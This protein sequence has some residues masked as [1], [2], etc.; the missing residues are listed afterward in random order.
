MLL[1]LL[2]LLLL[3]VLD[4]ALGLPSNESESLSGVEG[5][6]SGVGGVIVEAGSEAGRSLVLGLGGGGGT[7]PA[8]MERC[9]N[10]WRCPAYSKLLC[11]GMN[12]ENGNTMRGLVSGE[13]RGGAPGNG[14]NK[15]G[16]RL[17]LG[18]DSLLSEVDNDPFLEGSGGTGGEFKSTLFSCMESLSCVDVILSWFVANFCAN[19]LCRMTSRT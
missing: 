14:D 15:A 8:A 10:S 3:L 16:G 17:S 19:S 4:C 9:I 6:T 5:N 7:R 2:L 12:G 11:G 18:D 1:L 13:R